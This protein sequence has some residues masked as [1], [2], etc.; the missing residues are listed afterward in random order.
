[1]FA[2]NHNTRKDNY[3]VIKCEIIE[4][5]NMIDNEILITIKSIQSDSEVKNF[6]LE[7]P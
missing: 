2:I 4:Y 1:M 7:V 6:N 3:W 5:Y